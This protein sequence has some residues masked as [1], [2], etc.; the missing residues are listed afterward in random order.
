MKV[1]V[2]WDNDNEIMIERDLADHE[3]LDC[4]VY[5]QEAASLYGFSIDESDGYCPVGLC[6]FTVTLADDPDSVVCW[7]SKSYFVAAA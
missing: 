3:L 7:T 6:D 4:D 2:A 5:A 1:R